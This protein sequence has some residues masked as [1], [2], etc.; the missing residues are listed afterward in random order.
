VVQTA[1]HSNTITDGTVVYA[2]LTSSRDTVA[3]GED[4]KRRLQLKRDVTGTPITLT[5]A[6]SYT[7]NNAD[8]LYKL[9]WEELT[10]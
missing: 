5:L 6:V 10:N 1:V 3:I 2:G 9:G 8:L 4:L 7:A